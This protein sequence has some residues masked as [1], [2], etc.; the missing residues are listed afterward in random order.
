MVH[1]RS[2]LWRVAALFCVFLLAFGVFFLFFRRDEGEDVY[3]VYTAVFAVDRVVADSLRV[4]D[5]LIDARGKEGAGE[6]L[7]IVREETLFEDAHGVY[8]HPERVSVSLT[9]GG[10]GRRTKDG[11]RIGT[12]TPRVGDAVYL[13]GRVRLEG[14]CVR[15]G[16]I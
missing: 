6:I 14:L 9:L 7:K 16:A 13:L 11:A 1:A 2:F 8:S 15:V 3:L 5:P 10:N 4:G 12:L